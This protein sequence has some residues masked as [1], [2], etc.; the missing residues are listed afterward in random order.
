MKLVKGIANL[1]Y[2][3]RKDVTGW[4]RQGRM[5]DA[6]GRV[7]TADDDIPHEDVRFDGAPL[8]VAATYAFLFVLFGNFYNK[9][10]GGQLFFDL[11]SAITGPVA[12]SSIGI[13]TVRRKSPRQADAK[14]SC[15]TSSV[16]ADH[17]SPSECRNGAAWSCT[18]RSGPSLAHSA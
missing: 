10:G 15:L 3:S 16:P 7:L 13:R 17:A 4:L 9:A 5:T 2:G 18:N 8:E 14:C 12:R 1:G 6:R 11:A